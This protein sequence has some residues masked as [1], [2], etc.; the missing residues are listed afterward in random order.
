MTQ[1]AHRMYLLER[2]MSTINV[3]RDTQ[4]A[5]QTLDSRPRVDEGQTGGRRQTTV[6][7]DGYMCV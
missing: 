6:G 1:M 5:A 2:K 4:K 7:V 3:N